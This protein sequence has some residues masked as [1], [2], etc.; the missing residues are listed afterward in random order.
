M[1]DDIT[2]LRAVAVI[3]VL[4]F[5]SKIPLFSGG[6]LG[7]D[8]FFVI[9]GFLIVGDIVRRLENKNFSYL[10]FYDRR[11]RRILPAL[12]AVMAVVTLLSPF[13]MVPYDLKNFGQSLFASTFALNNVLL[14]LT[15]GYWSMAA[16]LKPLYHTWSL[17]VEEQFY[18]V[19]PLA[20]MLSYRWCNSRKWTYLT[21]VLIIILSIV[22]SYLVQQVEYNFLILFTRMWELM[23]GGVL[24]VY[25][26]KRSVKPC[27]YMAVIGIIL[28]A[29]PLV[30]PYAL[31]HNQAIVNL[32]PVLGAS[33]VIGF[34][35]GDETYTGRFLSTRVLVFIGLVSYSIYLWHQPLIAFCRL[36]SEEE[37]SSYIL[38]SVSLLSVPLAYI[39]WR[40]VENPARNRAYA[41][42]KIFYSVIVVAAVLISATGLVMHKT[43]GFEKFF[44]KYAYGGDPQV[45]VEGPYRYADTSA[46]E[47]SRERL[48]VLGNSFARDFINMLVEEGL[49]KRY[50][51]T[52]VYE[53]AECDAGMESV[54]RVLP[55]ARV[56]VLASN[57]AQTTP[58][59]EALVRL[60]R[61]V[62]QLRT[63]IGDRRLFVFGAKNFGYN[64][65]F[66]KMRRADR[67]Q[68]I[69]VKPLPNIVAFNTMAN[70]VIPNYIDVM[71][72]VAD[73][74]G[75]VNVFT[76]Q[77][78]LI[79]Y[80]TNHLTKDGARYL[81]EIVFSE[82][83][84]AILA[85]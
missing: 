70:R 53:G 41:P 25:M 6:F 7:V 42:P 68:S 15:S 71:S 62:N 2:G 28:I 73:Q 69:R 60:Q 64:N 39:T 31:S 54:E 80:D 40:F 77:G 78:R 67:L 23:I 65:N 82:S 33:L 11:A 17:G 27:E 48:V 55:R 72:L 58:A 74:D 8:L 13:L 75:R 20:L 16:E 85:K 84:L 4:L 29:F 26:D 37:P 35:G 30:F 45:Y 3:S 61:C 43:Y 83:E 36:A 34:A 38:A 76:D 32:S 22:H 46:V 12:L 50:H 59:D 1:R 79:T 10:N 52:Y 49:D 57:W 47:D 24:A 21:I 18:F 19:V 81:G 56:I 63:I 66:V 51:L 9:S 44:E 5:H 14:Y